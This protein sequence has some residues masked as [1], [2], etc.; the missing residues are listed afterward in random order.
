[1][2]EIAQP[3]RLLRNMYGAEDRIR[4]YVGILPTVLQTVPFGHFGTSAWGMLLN[5]SITTLDL[6]LFE[7]FLQ[8][9]MVFVNQYGMI[10]F[11]SVEKVFQT[12]TIRYL[13]MRLLRNIYIINFPSLLFQY[14][15]F[16]YKPFEQDGMS[17]LRSPIKVACTLFKVLKV[18]V[19]TFRVQAKWVHFVGTLKFDYEL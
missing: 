4:T 6:L 3:Y 13:G 12:F 2:S 1:M 9:P 18:W 16:E 14:S 5:T 11:R 15:R 19:Q 17:T 7:D 8:I 10:T